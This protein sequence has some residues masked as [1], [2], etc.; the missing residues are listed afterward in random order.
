MFEALLSLK[1]HSSW[2]FLFF[3]IFFCFWT[4]KDIIIFWFSNNYLIFASTDLFFFVSNSND[5][6]ILE[7][8]K[9]IL[10]EN[11]SLS[12]AVGKKMVTFIFVFPF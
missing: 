8:K 1:A 4:L 9:Q 7:N 2:N 3:L 5:I 6:F 12:L 11:S 10:L